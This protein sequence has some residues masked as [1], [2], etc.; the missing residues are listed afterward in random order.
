MPMTLT[1]LTG[2]IYQALDQVVRSRVGFVGA[3]KA[4]STD[5]SADSLALGQVVRIPIA[6]VSTAADIVPGQLPPDT[7]G[8]PITFKDMTLSK[9]RAVPLQW[10]GEEQKV[11]GGLL[12]GIMVDQFA[13]AFETLAYEIEVDA[14]TIALANAS[15]FVGTSGTLPFGIPGDLSDFA[16]IQRVL[17][18][19]GSPGYSR[20]LII[21][22]ASKANLR[23][24]QSVLFKANEAGT[25]ALLREGTIGRVEGLDIRDTR[26]LGTAKTAGTGA[27]YL[28][29]GVQARGATTITVI[30]GT[31]TILAGD[32]VT[33]AGFTYT[34]ATALTAGSFT[35]NSPGLQAAATGGTAVTVVGASATFT[36]RGVA[37]QKSAIQ[38]LFRTPA[39]PI[40]GDAADDV[41]LVTDPVSGLT[42]QICMYRQYKQIHIEVGLAWGFGVVKP[43]YLV[44]LLG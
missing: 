30:T 23:G 5:I 13:Q 12:S 8:Q 28:T 3:V 6:G 26:F 32:L 7:G 2:T 21:D 9:S 37:F 35:I 36:A 16:N 15:R 43:N 41:M 24:K 10:T 4:F 18:D 14:G 42:F 34:V 44:G 1:G 20:T 40:G 39:M 17:D 31:G 27:G 29:N 22:S 19:N 25:D 33:I 38:G 11:V